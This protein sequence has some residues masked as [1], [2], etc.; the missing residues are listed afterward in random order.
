MEPL[1]S[2]SHQADRLEGRTFLA[3]L[4]QQGLKHTTVKAYLSSLRYM[5]AQIAQNLLDPNFASTFP[6]LELTIKG[7]YMYYRSCPQH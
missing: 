4:A 7:I 6:K 1:Q 5:Y 3:L 2:A